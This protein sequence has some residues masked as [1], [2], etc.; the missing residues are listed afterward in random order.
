[1]HGGCEKKKNKYNPAAFSC[2]SK[3]PIL[4]VAYKK[5]HYENA[6]EKEKERG[7]GVKTLVEA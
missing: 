7:G 2:V 3:F 6:R 5:Q 4:S 1:M